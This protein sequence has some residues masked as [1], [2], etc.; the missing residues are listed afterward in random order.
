MSDS[1]AD[2]PV[3]RIA[4]G[5]ETTDLVSRAESTTTVP[6]HGV[7]STGIAEIE[8]L[9]I[10]T[11]NGHTAFYYDCAGDR[12]DA[13]AA[14]LETGD[15]PAPDAVSRESG[16]T[17]LPSPDSG[18]L[19]VGRRR[20]LAGCG[21][22]RPDAAD[23][24]RAAG[25]F[26]SEGVDAST[27]LEMS[28]HAQGRGWG[29]I[30]SGESLASHWHEA[31]E[32]AGDAAVVVNAHGSACDEL[33]VSSDPFAVLDGATVAATAIDAASVIVYT[34]ASAELAR[35]RVAT[36]AEAFPG[37]VEIRVESGPNRYRTAE[38][39]MALEAIEGADRIEARLRPP[40]PASNGI[41]GRPTLLHT[42]RTL[43]AIAANGREQAGDTRILTVTGDVSG[44]ATL[45]LPT[46]DSIEA[47]LEA[48]TVEGEVKAVCVGGRFGGLTDDLATPIDVESLASAGLGTEATLEV[49]TEER[50]L[51]AFTGKRTQW[52][53][54]VNCGR[55]VPCRE[56]STQLVELL[57]G[58]Y[59]GSVPADKV[60]ELS[61]VMERSSICQFGRD[62]PR[63]ARTALERFPDE[64]HAH[65]AGDCPAGVCDSSMEGSA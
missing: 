65:A 63:P 15:G 64:F 1:A 59:D 41:D 20:L 16:A 7:G 8:P 9:A 42:P 3:L 33:L 32:A 38:P 21:W 30:A 23:E 2:T 35:E 52:A 58:V 54:E 51:V 37:D 12:L 31:A 61:R 46:T 6:V 56:G 40:G 10:A 48:T 5:G 55:C 50:C 11:R 60:E 34:A 14:G 17:G 28:Q 44:P 18:P 27:A 36:A 25:G 57:R 45:E 13:I 26:V 19:S 29:D 39:T 49:L 4:S 62:V 43:A 22:R 53:S 24:Y 47:A